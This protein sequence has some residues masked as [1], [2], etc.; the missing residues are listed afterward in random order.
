MKTV[1]IMVNGV[2]G[3]IRFNN[4]VFEVSREKWENY[5]LAKQCEDDLSCSYDEEDSKYTRE[6]WKKLQDD[7]YDFPQEFINVI[8]KHFNVS[9]YGLDLEDAA[10]E[11]K[12]VEVDL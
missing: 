12:F 3:G 10:S 6:E 4:S 7:F 5:N 9:I 8:N 2:S 11:L 1:I